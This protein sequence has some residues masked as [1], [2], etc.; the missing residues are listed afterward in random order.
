MKK[1]TPRF[2]VFQPFKSIREAEP[3]AEL[4]VPFRELLVRP[5]V[6]AVVNH[7]TLACLDAAVLTLIPL[8]LATPINL[9]GLGL[10]PFAIGRCLSV[11]ALMVVLTQALFFAK[12]VHRWGVRRV[13]S[14]GIFAFIP[15][16]CLFPLA[17]I[18]ARAW[19]LNLMVWAVLGC[20]LACLLVM[21]MSYGA[22]DHHTHGAN[23][24]G[25]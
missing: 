15:V 4:P 19:G 12:I 7:A 1:G 3:L 6:I 22:W 20:Q 24:A 13:F 11:L 14:T 18:F 21:Q 2:N 16:F 17:N 25:I 5:V 23:G 9:G 10:S 8:F